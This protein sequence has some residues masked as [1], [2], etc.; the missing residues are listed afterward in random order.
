L[1]QR[2]YIFFIMHC[3]SLPF[4]WQYPFYPLWTIVWHEFLECIWIVT[5]FWHLKVVSAETYLWCNSEDSLSLS[6]LR[7]EKPVVYMPSYTTNVSSIIKTINIHINF[8][9]FKFL[10]KIFIE[11]HWCF[12]F[13]VLSIQISIL[14]FFSA[15]GT[16]ISCS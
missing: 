4:I 3:W 10:V 1:G 7:F 14:L 11:L 8:L 2:E 9:Y 15:S 5:L 16:D 6:D 12:K 13:L